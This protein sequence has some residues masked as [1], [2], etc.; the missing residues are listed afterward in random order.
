MR[1]H[2]A[3]VDWRTVAGD[4]ATAAIAITVGT[5]TWDTDRFAQILTAGLIGYAF[6][7]ITYTVWEIARPELKMRAAEIARH[8]DKIQHLEDLVT[9]LDN[10]LED[11]RGQLQD[12]QEAAA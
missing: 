2:L 8:E 6:L 10:E 9:R 1:A 3:C 4:L 12:A 5:W 7:L 11:T